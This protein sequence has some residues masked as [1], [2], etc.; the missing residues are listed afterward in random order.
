[1]ERVELG[2]EGAPG[3]SLKVDGNASDE[4]LALVFPG[5][6][7]GPERPILHFTHRLLR[8]QA[9]TA[10]EVDY[11]FTPEAFAAA[12]ESEREGWITAAA[13]S[14]WTWVRSAGTLKLLVGM[15]LDTLALAWLLERAN[16]PKVWLTPLL[17]SG[18]V[19]DA[20]V[21]D[22]EPGL[23]VAGEADPATPP[24]AL[25]DLARPGLHAQALPRAG[26]G[27]ESKDP[28]ARLRPS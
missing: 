21:R 28:L 14:A 6:R 8:R 22:A 17:R 15:W 24:E 20:L 5:L 18:D 3:A 7:Y 13:A 4:P 1:M 23:L 19:A 27:L 25:R 10:A 12:R 9:W 26:H 16:V 2:A 11:G